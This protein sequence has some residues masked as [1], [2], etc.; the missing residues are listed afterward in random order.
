M[1]NSNDKPLPAV[2]AYWI[3]EEH[4]HAL[5]TIFDDGNKMPQTQ[6]EDTFR[7]VRSQRA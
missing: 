3:K 4:H 1:A 5:R 6:D 7:K 2:G